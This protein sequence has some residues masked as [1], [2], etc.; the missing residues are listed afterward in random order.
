MEEFALHHPWLFINTCCIYGSI[1]QSYANSLYLYRY[2]AVS[3]THLDVYK[4]QLWM[5]A[6]HVLKYEEF[7][8]VIA[9]K[10]IIEGF[11]SCV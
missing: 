11:L 5:N 10:L 7:L 1:W 2:N 3:Y 8:Q 6:S 9:G 4:R